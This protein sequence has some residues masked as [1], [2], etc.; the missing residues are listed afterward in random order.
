MTQVLEER[1]FTKGR[2]IVR[3]KTVQRGEAK[4]ADYILFYKPNILIAVIE[5]KDNNHS[6]GAGMQQAL[7]YAEVLDVPFAYSS[8]DDGFVEHDRTGKAKTPERNLA[9]SEF[10][11]PEELWTRYS[12]VKG[13]TADQQAVVAQDYY[14]D[15]TGKT[16]HYFSTGCNQSNRGCDRPWRETHLAG[17]GDWDWKNL[18]RLS[19]HLALMESRSEEANSFLG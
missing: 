7:D 6:V 9:L 4:K 15:P 16:P 19:N 5:A 10:P 11:T 14:I 18:H 1:Y 13:Y 2:I 3:G 8:N 12:G 17:D